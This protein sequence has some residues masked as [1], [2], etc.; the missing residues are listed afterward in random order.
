[1]ELVPGTSLEKLI[2]KI[3]ASAI[4]PLAAQL[5]S[6]AKYLDELDLVHRD[7][8]PANIVVS[9]DFK[10]LT[11]LDLGIVYQLP[12]ED[13]KGR[14]SGMEFVATLRYSPPEF[15]WRVEQGEG[16]WRAVTFYQ[17]GATLH[18]LIM[19]TPLFSGYDTPRAHLYDSVRDRTPKVESDALPSWL[20]QTVQACLLKDWRQRL[21]FTRWESFEQG[22][23]T[24]NVQDWEQR[25]RL[26]QVRKE[27]VRQASI[28]KEK[29]MS[30]PTRE[31]ELWI[32]NNSLMIE[33]RTYLTTTSIFPRCSVLEKMLNERHYETKILFEED[34]SKGF[35]KEVVFVISLA[36]DNLVDG[37]TKLSF[38][39][40]ISE[41]SKSVATWTEMFTV[42]SAFATC[43]QSFLGA[44][45]SM[46]TT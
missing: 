9:D 12:T 33:V 28:Q 35:A 21:Q 1:M 32:L 25:I 29:K 20:I 27:E 24:C 39:A 26:A 5:A 15:V 17:I 41:Q 2:G 36:I 13:D 44:V 23:E 38:S 4:A 3:P 16:A 31:Q 46:I 7:I 10:K 18:D 19:G 30:G 40:A 43:R 6:V 42:E 37:A 11:L 34:E 14:I 22:N 8:K 45:E